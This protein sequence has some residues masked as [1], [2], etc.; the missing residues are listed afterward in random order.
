MA[1]HKPEYLV[2]NWFVSPQVTIE[3]YISS[4]SVLPQIA[5]LFY[6]PDTEERLRELLRAIEIGF[7]VWGDFNGL[8]LLTEKMDL[9]TL[10]GRLQVDKFNEILK[11]SG[12]KHGGREGK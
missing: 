10:K 12:T 5:Q 8:F 9:Q 6:Q 3:G 2:D 1:N 7:K 11:S 4:N